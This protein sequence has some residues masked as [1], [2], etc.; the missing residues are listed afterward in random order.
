M[1]S[2][3]QCEP[4][5]SMRGDV[6]SC[7]A[8]VLGIGRDELGPDVPLTSLGLESF[9]A[10]RLRRR[11][12]DRLGLDLPLT[13]FLGQASLRSLEVLAVGGPE[14]EESFPLTPV[15]AAY[16]VGRDPAFPLG[17]VATFYYYEYDRNPVSGD[18]ETDL[19]RLEE[20]WNRL[21]DRH[22]MLRM[23]VGND[24]RQRI[25]PRGRH[26]RFGVTD[27]R[28]VRQ[29]ECERVLAEL[30]QQKSH[31]VLSPD[32]GPLFDLHATFLPGGRTRI[33]FGVDVLAMDMAS[34]MLL[35]RQWR[36]LTDDPAAP[37]PS[38][39]TTFGELVRRRDTDAHRREEDERYWRTRAASLPGGPGLPWTRSA[40]EI[41]VP[42]FT[43]HEVRL[44]RSA[45]AR[46]RDR[47]A[48]EGISPTALLLTA[49]A[50]VLNRWGARDPFCLNATLF[51]RPDEP[52]LEHLVGDFTTTALIALPAV[53]PLEWPGFTDYARTVNHQFWADLDHRSVSGVEVIRAHGDRRVVDG[54]P[55]YPVV[56]TSGIGLGAGD[57]PAAAWLGEEV[58]G[59]SQTP[60]VLLD[61][62]VWE[63]GGVLRVAWDA[64]D[65][66][67]PPGYVD[68]MAAAY[69]RL[70]RRL[71]D[72]DV[73]W[74]DR[75][76]G[77]DPTFAEAEL[78]DCA[79]FGPVGELL[80]DPWRSAVRRADETAAVLQD[81]VAVTHGELRAAAGNVAGH[82]AAHGV[83][84]GD[85]VAVVC[86]KSADQITAALGIS[87]CGAGYVPV[88]PSWPAAR[89]ESICARA[90]VRHLITNVDLQAPLGTSVHRIDEIEPGGMTPG[91]P[92]ADELAYVIFTSGSTGSPK[93]VAV[94]HR[95]ARC[96]IDDVV[97][98]FGIGHDDRVL[99]L[100]A[101][102]FDLSVFDVYGV[103]GAGGALV[104]PAPER[105]RDPQ[106]WLELL[107]THRI[108]VWNT[109][110]ALLEMLVDYAEADQ[111]AAARDLRS[112]RLVMLSGD[113]IPVSLP[114][115]LRAM[116]PDVR[117]ISLGGA[118]EASIWSICHPVDEVD[119][120]WPSIPYGRALR[121]QS[122]QI[123]DQDGGP[124][125]VGVAG[126]L[127]I[128]GDGVARGYIGDSTQTADRFR[129]HPLLGQRLYRTGDLGR[130]RPDGTVEFLGRV[131]RQV[132]V[133]GH[134]IELGEIEAVLARQH[135][136]R[137]GV[138]SALPGPDQRPRLVAHVVADDGWD[139][140]RAV[141]GLA[142]R[143]PDY[144]IPARFVQLGAL[145]VT[146]NGKVDHSALPNPYA[147]GPAPV[148][149]V[150][151][152]APAD[153]WTAIRGEAEKR[154]LRLSVVVHPGDLSP[155]Q[156]LSAAG[157]W[158]RSVSG[159]AA[160]AGVALA[161]GLP[162]DGLIEL[163]PLPGA[164]AVVA[165]PR[166]PELPALS[167]SGAT[168]QE[169][170]PP[171]ADTGVLEAVREVFTE[172]LG[173]TVDLD[174]AFFDLGATS[175]NLVV[176]HRRLRTELCETLSVVDLFAQNTV[177]A[178][179]EHII[180]ARGPEVRAAG[181]RAADRRQARAMA[182]E[183][184][185]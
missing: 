38:A 137:R 95:M 117:F 10:V 2:S 31:Q 56:F 92:R 90:E 98:R 107:A 87:L 175:L 127:H 169:S 116:A 21:V 123:L 176:A 22:P 182:A 43:R 164:P 130:W 37:L 74:Q 86:T 119:P 125:P 15:Q 67:L 140:R 115:R 112:L 48:R 73:A 29:Q 6:G 81:G 131:D 109:A 166:A 57:E 27:L 146:A 47:S 104:L 77:W 61:H 103:L 76:L 52:G 13:A 144:M 114:D 121:G 145:P 159:A 1:S 154:G 40:G 30:R 129:T 89:L 180:G 72:D 106:H 93:G 42:R 122:F 110:P 28:A 108:T 41:G 181:G 94:E 157:E 62:I 85:L 32:T 44:D 9:L 170:S 171:V 75:C 68:G 101:L 156:A 45:W 65:E 161:E 53:D 126:E 36:V 88:E 97:D 69:L 14:N 178:L 155:A 184:A 51:D 143:L 111:E 136:V 46:L 139:E 133:R 55:P 19:K 172:L 83:G 179:A 66:A 39:P 118:T 18:Q 5:E 24:G 149:R 168:Q 70:L 141:A 153:L 34:W 185:R 11:L 64:V 150:A 33:H 183:L 151:E 8:E 63:E 100:S 138:V 80:H 148:A 12:R 3:M 58:F 82:L 158:A 135:G 124:V 113:W 167:S 7:V 160:R 49:F 91:E 78:L 165:A 132:K 17:G 50:L 84:P 105:Q 79:P 54:A 173:R 102:S 16:W 147:G 162:V 59:V 26:H 96:T 35:M 71:A 177:R 134:R 152:E 23:V 163:A 128:G 20:A 60:Q 25:G 142:Q 174:R 4:S 120:R 99:A